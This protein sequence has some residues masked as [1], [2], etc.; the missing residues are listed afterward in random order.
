M[1]QEPHG[2]RIEWLDKLD[3]KTRAERAERAAYVDCQWASFFG[4]HE[5]GHVRHFGGNIANTQLIELQWCFING[6]F[7]ACVML[8]QAVIEHMFAGWFELHGRTSVAR[9][10]L[11][12]MA[13][14]A[15]F[16]RRI[17]QQDFQQIDDLRDLR[18]L[19]THEKPA[20]HPKDF[21][22]RAAQQNR[23]FSGLTKDDA[24]KALQ[25]VLHT[26]SFDMFRFP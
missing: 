7:L 10:G 26:V 18:N 5:E 8:A 15:L 20:S 16:E 1:T 9:E 24:E 4:P 13:E 12:K 19:L 23:P 14:T 6:Q 3:A 25:T 17:S 11:L 2:K 21:F 22:T